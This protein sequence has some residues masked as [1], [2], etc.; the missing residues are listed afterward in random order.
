MLCLSETLNPFLSTTAGAAGLSM[1]S[2]PAQ[3]LGGYISTTAVTSNQLN[4]LFDTIT[5]AENQVSDVEYRCFFIHNTSRI[6][7]AQSVTLNFTDTVGGADIELAVDPVG[8]IVN[9]S[10][11]YQA[12]VIPDE[13]TAPVGPVFVSPGTPL[14]LG[15]IYPRFCVAIWAKRTPNTLRKIG[16][17]FTITLT[18]TPYLDISTVLPQIP[19]TGDV[20]LLLDGDSFELLDG[21][22]FYLLE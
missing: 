11:P 3:S 6:A 10:Y 13:D 9:T 14:Y 5:M 4:N 1:P 21:D 20:F 7:I 22:N 18:F 19:V 12:A 8:V 17:G 16:D 2:A 15:D